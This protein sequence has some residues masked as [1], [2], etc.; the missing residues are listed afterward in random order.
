MFIVKIKKNINSIYLLL[1]DFNDKNRNFGFSF[2]NKQINAF[3]LFYNHYIEYTNDRTNIKP[4]LLIGND[5]TNNIEPR[6][7]DIKLEYNFKDIKT[8]ENEKYSIGYVVAKYSIGYDFKNL[9]F[10]S[11]SD[12]KISIKDIIQCIGRGL[13]PDELGIFGSNKYKTLNIS[14]PV[15]INDNMNDNEY[16]R[17]IEVLKYLVHDI[18]MDIKD[19]E[20]EN[21]Y[22]PY[23]INNNMNTYTGIN[24]IQSKL[25]NLLDLELNKIRLEITY[26]KAKEI[27]VEKNIINKKSYFDLCEID[28]RLT[29]EPEKLYKN[30]FKNWID[31]LG[32]QRIYYDLET[33]K[34]KIQEYLLIYPELKI[35]YLDFFYICNQLCL[36]DKL[37]PPN[38]L[39]IDYYNVQNLE[40]IIKI[41]NFKKKTS[42]L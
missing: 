9:D 21:R 35:H 2:H 8:F 30:K 17:I 39:W 40:D 33:C 14:L 29:K 5:F 3:N 38:D 15:Y 26:E 4:F 23:S 10:I 22:H 27:I 13:R 7:Q 19:I 11:F 12:P 6:L 41:S 36:I 24:D 1:K 16:M 32:I 20:F 31:Y 28:Y 42:I 18:E 25:L 37:F 34:N